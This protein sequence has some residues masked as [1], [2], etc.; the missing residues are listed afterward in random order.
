MTQQLRDFK[1]MFKRRKTDQLPGEGAEVE[2]YRRAW[3]S[4]VARRN[5][6]VMLFISFLFLGLLIGKLKLGESTDF[7]IL[8][9]WIGV[10]LAGG[11]WLT[12][13]KCPRCGKV[14]GHRIWTQRCISCDLS[15][16]EVEAVVRGK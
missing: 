12:E 10:Y 6:V 15:K 7:L 5:L 2:V 11:W 14:F 13:W 8:L 9:G 16:D 1:R 4:Y 3:H